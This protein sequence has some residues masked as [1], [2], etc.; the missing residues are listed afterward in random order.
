M[1]HQGLYIAQQ[2]PFLSVILWW[3]AWLLG[4]WS[5]QYQPPPSLA[6]ASSEQLWSMR[7]I[8]NS[9]LKATWKP[10]QGLHNAKNRYMGRH[11]EFI[12]IRKQ[13]EAVVIS[14]MTTWGPYFISLSPYTSFF[15][16]PPSVFYFPLPMRPA[17]WS[18]IF[19]ISIGVVTIT[20]NKTETVVH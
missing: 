9:R 11:F 19:N 8:F 18:W 2:C 10:W 1:W 14:D 4:T 13:A 16:E 15:A 17:S 7:N 3:A 6:S 20:Y 12:T 5:P